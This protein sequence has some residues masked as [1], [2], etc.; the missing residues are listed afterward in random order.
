[1]LIFIF[2][3]LVGF[4]EDKMFSI[5]V[6]YVKTNQYLTNMSIISNCRLGIYTRFFYWAKIENIVKYYKKVQ[7]EY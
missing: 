6:H 5:L 7:K 3:F 1:M 2:N 4:K